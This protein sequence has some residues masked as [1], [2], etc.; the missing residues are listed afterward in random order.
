VAPRNTLRP[1]V[2][3]VVCFK[4]VSIEFDEVGIGRFVKQVSKVVKWFMRRDNDRS[5]FD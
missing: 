5:K 3:R 4:I 1:V 2:G